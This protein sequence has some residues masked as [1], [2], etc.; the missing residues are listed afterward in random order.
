MVDLTRIQ[1]QIVNFE[2]LW[3]PMVGFWCDTD[4][5]GG[6]GGFQILMTGFVEFEIFSKCIENISLLCII[7]GLNFS[8]LLRFGSR[9]GTRVIVH[10]Q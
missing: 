1:I 9:F 10:S 3:N 6:F 8:T 2:D 7:K 4:P 5:N